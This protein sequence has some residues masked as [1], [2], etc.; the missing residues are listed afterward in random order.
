[1]IHSLIHQNIRP[2]RRMFWEFV[3]VDLPPFFRKKT[4]KN[5]VRAYKKTSR[6]YIHIDVYRDERFFA[7]PPYF[8]IKK[9][10]LIQVE[11][12]I[13]FLNSILITQKYV[14]IYLI[15]LRSSGVII[16]SHNTDSHQ[17][18]ALFNYFPDIF[19]SVK[20]FC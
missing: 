7:V 13:S 11:K 3:A 1:M 15:R 12:T 2:L 10:R 16:I 18:S 9:Y 6:L 17:P 20:A 4:L 14:L 19:I 5:G 8:T